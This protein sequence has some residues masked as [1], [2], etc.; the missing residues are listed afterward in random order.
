VR[1]FVDHVVGHRARVC[2]RLDVRVVEHDRRLCSGGS[3]AGRRRRQVFRLDRVAQLG[4]EIRERIRGRLRLCHLRGGLRAGSEILEPALEEL[5]A[6]SVVI[7]GVELAIRRIGVL[8]EH[9]AV[10]RA[11]RDANAGRELPRRIDD[12]A[13]GLRALEQTRP[14]QPHVELRMDA[15]REQPNAAGRV[16]VARVAGVHREPRRAERPRVRPHVRLAAADARARDLVTRVVQHDAARR[17]IGRALR[18]GDEAT[19]Q[20]DRAVE[21]R[22]GRARIGRRRVDRAPVLEQ[23]RHALLDDLRRALVRLREQHHA[24][25]VAADVGREHLAD[26]TG[27]HGPRPARVVA[28]AGKGLGVRGRRLGGRDGFRGQ[29]HL[30]SRPG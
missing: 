15:Q 19:Q 8:L 14:A 16:A 29:G 7:V 18:L 24:Q 22:R 26:R 9:L 17:S 11:Q 30:T 23:Q 20:L 27:G 21:Q 25:P 1:G 4:D 12:D 5:A 6:R 2:I 28:I 3:T 13:L 10:H